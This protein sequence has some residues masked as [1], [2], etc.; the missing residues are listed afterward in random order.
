MTPERH[1]ADREYNQKEFA[2]PE[3][4]Q[5]FLIL[6][7]VDLFNAGIVNNYPQPSPLNRIGKTRTNQV[8][9][10]APRFRGGNSPNTIRNEN[11]GKM[12]DYFANEHHD[13]FI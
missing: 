5:F 10:S 13:V 11:R 6:V 3:N 1:A 7:A 4:G 8:N 12:L 9:G 2:I